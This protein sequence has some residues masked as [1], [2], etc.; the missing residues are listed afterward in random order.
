MIQGM[1]ERFIVGWLPD[2]DKRI[3]S[4]PVLDSWDGFVDLMDEFSVFFGA[5]MRSPLD[6]KKY[7]RFQHLIRGLF[8]MTMA[9]PILKQMNGC[10]EL[11]IPN[12]FPYVTLLEP[13]N[14]HLRVEGKQVEHWCVWSRNGQISQKTVESELTRMQQALT[15][16]Y[17]DWVAYV[18][19]LP[20]RSVPELSHCQL[21]LLR[22]LEE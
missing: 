16:T 10:D 18:H 19:P 17:I 12:R 9:A 4:V 14:Q 2:E 15:L 3:L 20:H 22:E 11:M 1:A 7:K 21:F 5:N 13:L 6:N 8:G